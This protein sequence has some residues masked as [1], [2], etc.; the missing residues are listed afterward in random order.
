MPC[1][2]LLE[3]RHVSSLKKR[4]AP[5]FPLGRS[6]GKESESC[7]IVC[8]QAQVTGHSREP[9]EA[10]VETSILNSSLKGLGRGISTTAIPSSHETQ[11]IRSPDASVDRLRSLEETRV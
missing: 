2:V 4:R 5:S 1:A 9:A 6:T 11:S 8:F 7:D 10:S 3:T